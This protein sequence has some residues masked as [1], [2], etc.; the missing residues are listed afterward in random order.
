[1]R[2]PIQFPVVLVSGVLVLLCA[3]AAG[4]YEV[5]P[6]ENGGTVTGRVILKTD[7]AASNTLEVTTDENVCG[8]HVA[9][10]SLLVTDGLV[11]NVVVSIEGIVEGKPPS[12]DSPSLTNVGCRFVPHVQTIQ[13]GQKLVI[14][15][16]DPILHNS[17][18]VYKGGRTAFNLALPLQNQKV[19]KKIRKPGIIRLKCDAGHTWMSGYILAFKHPY[20]AVTGEDGSFAIHDIPPGT[21]TLSVWHE[22]LPST[23][24]EVLVEAGRTQSIEIT[25]QNGE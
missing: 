23:T 14:K 11:Q 20:H 18:A 2:G 22:S 21:Y 4:A 16:E 17:H 10:E 6:V 13:T 5:K 9:D 1:M 12:G 7:V 3:G 19:E 24:V 8:L 25:L 15:N